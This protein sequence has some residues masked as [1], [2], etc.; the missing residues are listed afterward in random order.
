[1]ISFICVLQLKRHC[2]NTFDVKL[3]Q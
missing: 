2:R 3:V 1:M